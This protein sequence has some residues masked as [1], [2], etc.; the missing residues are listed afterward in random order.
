[1]DLIC[2]SCQKRLT[3]EDQYAGMVVQCPLCGGMLQAP[4]LLG[5]PPPVP[6]VPPAPQ[7]MP[8]IMPVVPPVPSISPMPMQPLAPPAP[9]PP[10]PAPAPKPKRITGLPPVSAAPPPPPPPLDVAEVVAEPLPTPSIRLGEYAKSRRWHLRP[11]I[12]EWIAPGCVIAVFFLSW[13]SWY[14]REDYSLNLWDLA[15]TMR[16]H[17]IYTFYT[18]VFMFLALPVAVIVCC[19]EKS[20]IPLPADLRPFWPWRSLIVGG[21]IALPFLFLLGDYIEFQFLPF[22]TQAAIAM[23]LAFRIHLVAV[24]ACALQFWLEQRKATGAPMPRFTIRW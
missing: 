15:F 2:P 8:A 12:L 19:L 7:S 4:V 21:M 10:P 23:K 1:M 5:T 13:F 24:V 22:G 17:S 14:V 9:P 18:V 20:W 16:G 3:I 6:Q 11:D